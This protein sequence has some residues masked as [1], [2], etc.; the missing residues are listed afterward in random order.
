[1][2]NDSRNNDL[3]ANV[4]VTTSIPANTS[5]TPSIPSATCL[6]HFQLPSV[7]SRDA[8]SARRLLAIADSS[9]TLPR[10][11]G[12]HNSYSDNTLKSHT[13][14]TLCLPPHSTPSTFPLSHSHSSSSTLTL[15]L[16][17]FHTLPLSHSSSS[18]F[19]T[20][21][22]LSTSTRELLVCIFFNSI[23]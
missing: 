4:S 19:Y 11:Q 7:M 14:T 17:L 6:A 9:S 1:M 23:Y 20:L 3:A 22:T 10:G 15:L 16:F 2:E 5:V 21:H 8:R 13:H 12:K 18:T